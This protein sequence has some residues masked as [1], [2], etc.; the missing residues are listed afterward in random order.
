MNP[1]VDKKYLRE[2]RCIVCNK[3]LCKGRLSDGNSFLEVKC[4][5]CGNIV[6]FYGDDREIVATRSTLI[7]KGLIP[8]TDQN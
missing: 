4:R 2:Y 5:G 3:L 6:M 1:E 7:R 8:D